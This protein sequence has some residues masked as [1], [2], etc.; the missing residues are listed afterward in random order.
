MA[1]TALGD[2]VQALGDPIE[3]AGDDAGGREQALFTVSYQ[4]HISS[5]SGMLIHTLNLQSK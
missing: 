1:G 5:F 3:A 4:Q 2:D